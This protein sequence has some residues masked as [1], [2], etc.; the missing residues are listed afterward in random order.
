MKVL[1]TGAFGNIGFNTLQELVRQGLEVHTFDLH[2]P[3]NEKKAQQ[4]KGKIECHWGDVR[5]K[6]AVET[7]VQ[8]Q[9][10][11]IH[12]AY[13]IPPTSDEKPELAAAVNMDGTRNVIEAAKKLETP[14]RILFASTLDVFGQTQDQ[15]PPRKVTDPI[16]A[17]DEYSKHKI[18]GEEMVQ[19]SGL[20]WA[21]FRFAD[22]PLLAPRD[23]HP[24]MFRIPLNT[25]IE[26]LHPLD[27]GL[28][29][30]NGIQSDIWGK[31]WLIGGGSTCQIHYRD[32]LNRVMNAMGIG[33]LP[34]VAFSTEQ[35]CTDW[36]DTEESQALLHYQRHTA[37]EILGDMIQ[38]S[39][40]PAI[41]RALMPLIRPLARQS[42]LKL[43]PHFKKKIP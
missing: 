22:V 6:E 2:T 34:E 37:D 39:R 31:I 25:R 40:P 23:P 36:L 11:V 5:E 13:I 42:I 3:A 41:T 19:A 4:L 8:E 27:A 18:A 17:T 33:E 14:P 7:A 16:Q 30:T 24:I 43:S 28:A 10:V 26:V 1:L 35:Y 32:Y 12:F 29:V 20:Q 9:D 38:A 21:I 15:P